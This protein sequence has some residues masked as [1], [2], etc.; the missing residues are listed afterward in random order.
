MTPTPSQI[1]RRPD[2]WPVRA[3]KLIIFALAAVSGASLFVMIGAI[4]LDVILRLQWVH[5]VIGITLVGVFDVVRITGAIT[6]AAALPYTTA[7]KGHV[8]I[9]YFFTS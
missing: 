7:V 9:E 2:A 4:C 1:V 8:A 3:L 6:L 5:K